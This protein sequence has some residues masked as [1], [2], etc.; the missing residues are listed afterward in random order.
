MV[1]VA[2]LL[3]AQVEVVA[4]V[5]IIRKRV[6]LALPIKDLLAALEPPSRVLTVVVVVV[7]RVILAL[8]EPPRRAVT[9][10]LD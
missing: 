1:R 6:V 4:A 3:A 2:V 9:V 5:D 7:E 8:S 10:A